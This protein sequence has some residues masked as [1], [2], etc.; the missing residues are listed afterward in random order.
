M[1]QELLKYVLP[2]EIVEYF[3]LT[4]IS[5]D[6][7]NELEV[8]HLH[9]DEKNVPPPEYAHIKL[10]GNG[11]YESSAIKDFPL[12]DRKVYLHVRR[13]WVDESG[14]S[15]SRDWDLVAEGTRYSKELASLLKEK[16]G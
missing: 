1:L 13:R 3:E 15:Y 7:N 11:F 14:K 9:L 16:F 2:K 4:D 10:S 12:R 5:T 8:L 6:L